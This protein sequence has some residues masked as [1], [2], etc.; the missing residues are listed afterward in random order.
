[1]M[2]SAVTIIRDKHVFLSDSSPFFFRGCRGRAP[3]ALAWE[4]NSTWKA[5]LSGPRSEFQL[6]ASVDS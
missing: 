5:C 3:Q 6:P 4:R 2:K 1:M